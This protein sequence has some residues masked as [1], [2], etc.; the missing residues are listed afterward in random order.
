M[1]YHR[2][3]NESNEIATEK[4]A[5]GQ[6]DQAKAYPTGL[7][8]AFIF[9][10]L[11]MTTFLCAIDATILATAVPTITVQFNSLSDVSW[12]NSVF[13]L[14][15]CAFT[16]P[17]GRMYALTSTKWTYISSVIFFEIGSAICGAAPNSVSLIIGRAIA[18]LGG[19]GI[20]GG[21]FIIIAEVVPLAKRALYVGSIGGIFAVASVIGPPLGK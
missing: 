14:T 8:T 18:G 7:Q 1:D 21:A 2:S 12:Y 3:L 17:Y 13:L 9:I 20:F 11:I 19:A 10:P 6:S 5:D 16:L 4:T 15:A